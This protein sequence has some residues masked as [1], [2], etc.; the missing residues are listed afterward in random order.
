MG[1]YLTFISNPRPRRKVRARTV[2]RAAARRAFKRNPGGRMFSS[3]TGNVIKTRRRR[4]RVR[5]HSRPIPGGSVAFVHSH[6][7]NPKPTMAKRR[8]THRRRS[9]KGYRRNPVNAL[10]LNPRRRRSRGRR[11]GYRRNPASAGALSLGGLRRLP[12]KDYALMAGGAVAGAFLVPKLTGSV[13]EPDSLINKLPGMTSKVITP[14]R[15]AT[16][17]APAVAEVRGPAHELL[18]AAYQTAIGAGLGFLI[19]QYAHKTLGEGLI[20]G[21]L[22]NGAGAAVAYY[23]A[24][25]AQT[26]EAYARF[27]APPRLQNV[28]SM[29]A[30][31]SNG[32]PRGFQRMA[33]MAAF[34]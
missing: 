9:R 26:T 27:A 23:Q 11:R 4:H 13:T 22:A 24:Q 1:N 25:S 30:L 32:A 5:A 31:G 29:R 12:W 18:P 3:V 28:G 6:D 2:R 14:A 15:A 33:T 21:S 8:K 20:V 34:N 7:R 19:R 17:T 16:A 10:A